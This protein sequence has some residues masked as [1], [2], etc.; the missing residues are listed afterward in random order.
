MNTFSTDT[1]QAACPE[2]LAGSL[3]SPSWIG[4]PFW[5]FQ[6]DASDPLSPNSA[7]DRTST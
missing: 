1:P 5:I 7:S 6:L 3:H 2:A 4:M